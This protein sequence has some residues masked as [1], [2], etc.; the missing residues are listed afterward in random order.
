MNTGVTADIAPSH[1]S[2]PAAYAKVKNWL[3]RFCFHEEE[4]L[5]HELFLFYLVAT[6]KYLD[7]RTPLHF[8]RLVLSIYTLQ[9]QLQ[10]AMAF[11]PSV[12]HLRSHWM[13]V[14]LFFPFSSKK[15]LGCLVGFN[16]MNRYELFDEENILLALQKHLPQLR[17]VKESVY[18]HASQHKDLKIFYFEVEK[19]DDELFTLAERKM[20]KNS[21]EEKIK[22]SIQLLSP[23]VFTGL[24]EEE[25]Y[26]NI[27]ALNREIESVDDL[28]QAHI[29]LDQQSGK[30]IIFRIILVY[31]TP[32]HRFSLKERFFDATFISER[33]LT[34][35]H[36]DHRPIEAHIFRLVLPRDVSCLRS[37]GSLDYYCAREKVVRY[38]Q[39]AVG[40]F[41]DFNGGILLKQQELFRAFEKQFPEEKLENPEFLAVFFYTLMP[42]EKRIVLQQ[43][44]L[45]TLFSYFLKSRMKKMA[46]DALYV[47]DV[48]EHAPDFYIIIRSERSSF[49][50]G[51]SALLQEPFLD[52]LN[53]VYHFIDIPEGTFFNCAVI[54]AEEKS[55]ELLLQSLQ[56]VLK[57]WHQDKKNQQILR[58]AAEYLPY[59][60][61][62]RI[63]GDTISGAMLRLLFEGLTRFSSNGVVE[64]ALAESID[65]SP[66][67]K[68]Y[69]FKLRA[70]FWNDGSSVTAYDFEYAWKKILSPNFK[71]AFATFFYH[72]KKAKEAK[73][74][75]VSLDQI[76]IEVIDD[77]TLKIELEHPTPYFLQLTAFPL[78]SPVHR[79]IDQRYPQ[80]PYQYEKNYPCNG[81]FQLKIQVPNQR[82]QFVKNPL[83]WE[84]N[85]IVLDKIIVKQMNTY[86]AAQAFQRN[87]LDW[88]GNPLGGWHPSYVAGKD[89]AVLSFPNNLICWFVFNT[90][91]VL[92]KN[93]KL[94]EAIALI[95]DR[96]QLCNHAFLP[97]VPAY[98]IL[99]PSLNSSNSLYPHQDIDKARQLFVEALNEIGIERGQFPTI[100]LTFHQKGISA[101]V[102]PYLKQQ[103]EEGLG[104]ECQ[105]APLSW[106]QFFNQITEGRCQVSLFHWTF[107]MDEPIYT[108]NAFR[109]AKEEINF[110]R[111]ENAEFQQLLDITEQE[112]NPFQRSSNLL[113]AEKILSRDMP[114]IP[115]FCQ[116]SQV[117]VK[118]SWHV[119]KPF[120]GLFDLSRTYKREELYDCHIARADSNFNFSRN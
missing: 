94:R 76:G 7:H 48:Y 18:C 112:I 45:C 66:C 114:V 10:H 21:L 47:F 89:D 64:N 77:R 111:W 115:L 87:E 103:L 80:W 14:D 31:V 51:I 100:T 12:R 82:Y 90:Q 99:S 96:S 83:Y 113:Q 69:I 105:L 55:V 19:R 85:Q 32:Y 43:N 56:Q 49:V 72:I 4:P 17:L 33:V 46:E 13:P 41:R 52:T 93:K 15:A 107:W 60:L 59:S 26:K 50:E 24:N 29:T 20:L 86:Q 75:K 3:A 42:L 95:I 30:G 58:I 23:S 6:K 84:A 101:A 9:K 88:I 62:P 92:F 39:A 65:I 97:L 67:Q 36:L 98:S 5:F 73:E 44:S 38:M 78:Y 104:I 61:D 120:A 116:P 91:S 28:P 81:P 110:S 74:G 2:F 70:S 118:K 108:L 37:D 71:T 35:R 25:T 27:L 22:N 53:F 8:F 102:A 54:Q 106:D 63:G 16:I 34:V 68:Q 109:F 1:A 11:S 40:E 57:R 117:L 79:L 119:F